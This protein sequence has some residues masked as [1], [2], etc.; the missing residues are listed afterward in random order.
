[1]CRK[2]SSYRMPITHD[3]LDN[4]RSQ[5]YKSAAQAEVCKCLCAACAVFL[6]WSACRD[7]LKAEMQCQ[8]GQS[9]SLG[10]ELADA[11]NESTALQKQLHQLQL[12]VCGNLFAI[13]KTFSK[14]LEHCAALL[15]DVP[16]HA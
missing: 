5:I 15:G 2:Q 8:L 7:D 9:A 13:S 14:R 10:R 11:R 6:M 4:R 3:V 16:Y 1:M 12:Q